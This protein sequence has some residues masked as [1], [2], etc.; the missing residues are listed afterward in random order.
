VDKAEHEARDATVNVVARAQNE[1]NRIAGLG[2]A[3]KFIPHH[4]RDFVLRGLS[5]A[6]VADN[7][8]DQLLGLGGPG[9]NFALADG[10][11][12]EGDGVGIFAI[13]GEVGNR[14]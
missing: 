3:L 1:S 14:Y 7:E 10:L 8:E 13:G 6:K 5:R 4:A 11:L 9:S 12:P 2:A